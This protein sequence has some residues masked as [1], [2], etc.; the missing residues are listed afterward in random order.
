M[1]KKFN[2]IKN[3]NNAVNIAV[4]TKHNLIKTK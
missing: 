2:K 3:K 4:G 1:M